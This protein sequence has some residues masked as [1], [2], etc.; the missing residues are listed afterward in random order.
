MRKSSASKRGRPPLQARQSALP[1]YRRIIAIREFIEVH[2]KADPRQYGARTRAFNAAMD[3][4]HVND[5]R[6]LQR[7]IKPNPKFE[8]AMR[9]KLGEIERKSA[10]DKTLVQRLE[11]YYSRR[12]AMSLVYL[13]RID[14]PNFLSKLAD[15]HEELARLR[16]MHN[17][18][19]TKKLHT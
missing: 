7:L 9:I 1:R 16:E 18:L 10:A 3:R 12:D 11:K 17:R 13:T 8:E 15:T 5:R 4:Y 6:N 14:I 19:R 2:I